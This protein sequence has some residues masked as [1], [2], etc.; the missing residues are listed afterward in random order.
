MKQIFV[1]AHTKEFLLHEVNHLPRKIVLI[2]TRNPDLC[3][4]WNSVTEVTNFLEE[5]R[6]HNRAHIYI[7]SL[8]P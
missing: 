8:L 2:W 3:L 4:T 6:I 1:L 7:M 5:H